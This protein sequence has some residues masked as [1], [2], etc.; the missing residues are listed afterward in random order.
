MAGQYLRKKRINPALLDTYF[1]VI[2]RRLTLTFSGDGKEKGLRELLGE[3]LDNMTN[4]EYRTR[5]RSRLEYLSR[6]TG[7]QVARRLKTG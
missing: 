5:H 4:T 2:E 6:L 3:R 7:E 1:L